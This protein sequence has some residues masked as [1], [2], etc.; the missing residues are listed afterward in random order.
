MADPQA[1]QP[2]PTDEKVKISR[3]SGNLNLCFFI[4][5]IF[6]VSCGVYGMFYQFFHMLDEFRPLGALHEL[7]ITCFGILMFLLDAPLNFKCLIKLK[8]NVG[9]YAR[10]LNRLTGKGLWF[11]FLGCL[12]FTT[13]FHRYKTALWV[14]APIS[15]Y[16]VGLGLFATGVGIE[17]SLKWDRV[18]HVYRQFSSSQINELQDKYRKNVP[19][20]LTEQEFMN[21]T[22]EITE[23]KWIFD[24]QESGLIFAALTAENSSELR[25]NASGALLTKE[26]MSE[27]LEDGVIIGCI[28]L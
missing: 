4:A 28:P 8:A 25:E 14:I 9:R 27:W 7:Y 6:V 12:T 17:K 1:W 22:L 15:I 21:M 10:L 3:L 26:N 19:Y 18:R 11:T 13:M 2:V 23:H 24:S 20:G 16:I 5:S